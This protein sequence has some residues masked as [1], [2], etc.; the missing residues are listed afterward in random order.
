VTPTLRL[1]RVRIWI[2][3]VFLAGLVLSGLT[4]FPIATEIRFIASLELPLPAFAAEWP[5]RVEAAVDNAGPLLFYGTEWFAFAHIVIGLAFIGP[6]RDPVRN[7]W[8]VQWA[9]RYLV[10]GVRDHSTVDGRPS[11]QCARCDVTHTSGAF[12]LMVSSL[13]DHDSMSS[14]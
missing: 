5:T 4:A 2:V 3:A 12:Q 6:L 8:V 14:T 9:D 11:D 1:R 10:R 13:V 7:R